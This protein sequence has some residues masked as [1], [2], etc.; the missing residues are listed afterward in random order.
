[1]VNNADL[2]SPQIDISLVAIFLFWRSE[3]GLH[4]LYSYSSRNS[5]RCPP[6]LS[7]A[8]P[9]ETAVLRRRPPKT[10]LGHPPKRTTFYMQ[11]RP[12]KSTKCMQTPFCGFCG[13]FEQNPRS[14]KTP[15]AELRYM[16]FEA[17][18]FLRNK[19]NT[20]MNSVV[21]KAC[22]EKLPGSPASNC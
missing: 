5:S 4:F 8:S 9:A 19:R 22:L 18:N 17:Q 11:C 3:P 20:T 7:L 10:L 2:V 13:G 1:M 16:T 6:L 15:A 14:T 12:R 21:W